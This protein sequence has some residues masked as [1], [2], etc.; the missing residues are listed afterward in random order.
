MKNGNEEYHDVPE[1]SIKFV[2]VFVGS[3]PGP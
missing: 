1:A 2:Y 3:L